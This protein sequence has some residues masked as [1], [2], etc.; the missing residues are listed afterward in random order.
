VA[1]TIAGSDSGGGAGIQADL[2]TFFR[3]GVYGTS[4]VTA[5]TAQNTVGVHAWWEVPGEMVRAQLDAVF[6]DLPPRA[7]KTGMLATGDVAAAVATALAT[8]GAVPRVVDPVMTATSGDRLAD[9]AVLRVLRES[10]IPGAALVTPN[11]HEAAALTGRPVR[12]LDDQRAAARTLVESGGARAALVK[13]GHASGSVLVDV[14]FDGEWHELSHT[15]IATR[16]THGTG[17]TLSAA[18][19]A[20]LALGRSLHDAVRDAVAY[21]QRAIAAAPALGAADGH[22]PVDHSA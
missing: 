7:L 5:V 21:V 17:C 9:D 15:R 2:R 12:T 19:V 18:V 11:L 16:G 10:L 14:L 4:V 1:L 22:G 8:A 3:Y 20:S 6:Q 13:G